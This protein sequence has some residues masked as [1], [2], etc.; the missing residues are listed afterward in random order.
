LIVQTQ[1]IRLR[2]NNAVKVWVDGHE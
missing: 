2:G 1:R